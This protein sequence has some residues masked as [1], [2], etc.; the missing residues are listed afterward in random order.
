MVMFRSCPLVIRAIGRNVVNLQAWLYMCAATAPRHFCKWFLLLKTTV[1]Y[2]KSRE[3]CLHELRVT[4]LLVVHGPAGTGLSGNKRHDMPFFALR[5]QFT[6]TGRSTTTTTTTKKK[7]HIALSVIT[8]CR[9]LRRV[10]AGTD[11][12]SHSGSYNHFSYIS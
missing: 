11:I 4:S 8:R 5:V 10:T 7:S 2:P 12:S 9:M 6:D 1:S 3:G